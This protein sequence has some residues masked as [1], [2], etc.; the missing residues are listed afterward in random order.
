MTICYC[1]P[2]DPDEKLPN[3]ICGHAHLDHEGCP[4]GM[5]TSYCFECECEQYKEKA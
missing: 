2:S 3:C 5:Q 4:C 1:D